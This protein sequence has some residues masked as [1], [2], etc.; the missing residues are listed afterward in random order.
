[1]TGL[2]ILL[3]VA[4]L[5]FA[6]YVRFVWPWT[7]QEPFESQTKNDLWG[8]FLPYLFG[9]AIVA[10]IVGAIILKNRGIDFG[11]PSE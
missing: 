6:A 10:C 1:M 7:D 5:A 11:W 8:Y 9:L 2:G 4:G 3:I